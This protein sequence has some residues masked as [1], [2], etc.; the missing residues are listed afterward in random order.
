MTVRVNTHPWIVFILLAALIVPTGLS[1]SA[2][3]QSGVTLT[4]SKL[5][6]QSEEVA[7]TPSVTAEAK[8]NLTI[9]VDMPSLLHMTVMVTLDVTTSTG[10]NATI[11]PRNLPFTQSGTIL[12]NVTVTV[13]Q[14]TRST[15]IGNVVVSGL[16]TYPGG[17][18]TATSSA[19]VTVQQYYRIMMASDYNY[20]KTT[21]NKIELVL[22]IYNRGNGFDQFDILVTNIAAMEAKGMTV[23]LNRT[24]TDPVTPNYFTS[25]LITITYDNPNR[26]L[27]QYLNL[28]VT[29][30]KAAEA[31]DL[32]DWPYIFVMD[33]EP[34]PSFWHFLQDPSRPTTRDNYITLSAI[35]ATI[36]CVILII[37][38]VNPR[39]RKTK[40]RSKPKKKDLPSRHRK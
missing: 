27:R 34:D 3:S 12:L 4:L 21:G 25:V 29:S 38:Y 23:A 2:Q 22:N 9:T 18:K 28:Y 40:A 39:K 14:A 13:P 1:A 33:F 15:D 7:V 20:Q 31:K 6:P 17:T 36:I 5:S 11:S 30:V 32:I 16:A 8:F 26:P 35:V 37:S 10:W 24:R 19:Q